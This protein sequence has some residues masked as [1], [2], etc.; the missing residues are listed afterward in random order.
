MSLIDLIYLTIGL[1]VGGVA[2]WLAGRPVLARMRAQLENDRAVHAE[3][4]KTY[5]DA[6]ARFREAF[7]SLS[8][9]ALNKNNEA[10]L[11][12]AETRLQQART[13][14][15]ADIDARKKAIEDLLAPMAKTLERVDREIKDAERRRV[16][17]RREPAAAGRARSTR[18]AR[19]CRRKRVAWST[20]SSGPAC[21]AAGA[22]CS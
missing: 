11:H 15:T 12:L 13:E 22:S 17:G 3:R 19:T 14:A 21:A 1:I 2:T 10:F 8:A 6:E 5:A 16:A 18:S 20:R 4:L 7:A 9:Q